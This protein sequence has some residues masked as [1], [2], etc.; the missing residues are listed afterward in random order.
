MKFIS[1]VTWNI[2]IPV[3][4]LRC[5]DQISTTYTYNKHSIDVVTIFKFHN[6]IAKYER[7]NCADL[8]SH[9]RFYTCAMIKSEYLQ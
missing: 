5:Q 1:R 4:C 6:E 7:F 8:E 9:G 3:F 2:F